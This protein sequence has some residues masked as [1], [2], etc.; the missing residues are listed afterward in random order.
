MQPAHGFIKPE[1]SE[2]RSTIKITL[3]KGYLNF[4]SYSL[5]LKCMAMTRSSPPALTRQGIREKLPCRQLGRALAH[6]T[7]H[8]FL[9]QKLLHDL[10]DEKHLFCSLTA[11]ETDHGKLATGRRP[12][13]SATVTVETSDG[14]SPPGMTPVAV[15]RAG[16]PPPSVESTQGALVGRIDGGGLL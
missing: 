11:V 12:E 16:D 1:P 7:R 9:I 6:A 4:Y 8:Q 10:D 15:V 14:T 13:I 3:V 2:A 5:I